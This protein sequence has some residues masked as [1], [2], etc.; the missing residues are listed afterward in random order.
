VPGVEGRRISFSAGL[1]T[2]NLGEPFAEAINRAD[3]A[4]YR[5]K[6]SGRDRVVLA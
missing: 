1:A 5:A 2:R 4:L 6:E 3:K